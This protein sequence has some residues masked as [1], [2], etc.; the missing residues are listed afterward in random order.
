[1]SFTYK[2]LEAQ[3]SRHIVT[4]EDI[5]RQMQRMLQQ[6]PRITEITDR[7]T[8]LGDEVVLD[9]AGFCDGEQFAGGTAEMQTLTL[10]SGAFIPGFE[11][12][13]V[14]KLPGDE[15]SVQVTFPEVYHSE[16]LA[17]KAAEFKCKIHQIRVKSAYEPDDTFAQEIGGCQT[18]AE[19]RQKMGQS[20]QAYTD[21]RDEMQLQEQLL[22]MA[23]A[24][25]ELELS[26]EQIHS[27]AQEQLQNMKAQLAQQGL[28]LEMYC[29]FTNT[30]EDALLLQLLPQA[31]DQVRTQAAIDEIVALEN[32][33]V[34]QQERDEAITLIARQNG[35]TVEQIQPYCDEAFHEAVER[36][37]L[38]SK[39]MGVIRDNAVLR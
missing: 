24:T 12:Q 38:T 16:A 4:D 28:T 33:Q 29:T 34:T 2:G 26:Q 35:L 18:Y 7:P 25:L 32:L 13:L 23:A 31:E 6:N 30:T 8:Q 1:M 9:Y 15:V 5:D 14:G 19:M 10:G 36:S 27:A 21:D 17:G 37:V 20:L 3:H 11:E 22:R 39:A